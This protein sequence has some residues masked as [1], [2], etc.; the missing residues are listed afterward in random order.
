MPL[1]VSHSLQPFNT[2]GLSQSCEQ[3]FEARTTEELISLTHSF[4]RKGTPALVLGGGSNLVFLEDYSGAV[5][6]VLTKG[7]V[8]SEDDGHYY[9]DVAAGEN[10]HALIEYCLMHNM[11]GLENMALIPGTVGAAPI[12]N[13]GAYGIELCDVCHWVEYFNLSTGELKRLNVEDCEFAYRESVFKGKLRNTAVITRVGLK[14]AKQWLPRLNYGPLQAFDSKSV[15]AREIFEAVCQVRREKLPDPTV[16]G[17]V[18]SFFKNPLVDVLT[19]HSLAKQYPN[20]VGYA[21]P[22]GQVKLAAGWLIEAA[23]LKGFTLGNAAVHQK[24]ALVLVNNGGASGAEICA[25]AKYVIEQVKHKFAVVLE[26]EPRLIGHAG[27]VGIY[28]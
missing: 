4:Y 18:G 23:G 6:R 20:I 15:T 14:L 22:D 17:N 12:Q 10:W 2:L 27:E 8:V 25:L 11:P 9:L 19:Y 1:S 13:I 24:Q 28:D 5:I 7:I 3:I 21:Q 26:P 16:L